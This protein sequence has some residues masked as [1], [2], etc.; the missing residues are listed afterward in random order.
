MKIKIGIFLAFIILLVLPQ[1]AYSSEGQIFKPYINYKT[2]SYPEAVAIGDV[3][4]DGK[5]DVVMTTS[6]S[7]NS[8]PVNDYKLFVFIQNSAG[9]LNPPIKYSVS[10]VPTSVDICDLN[11]DGKK[12]VV[13][14]NKGVN[15]EV[16]IQNQ[17]GGLDSGVNYSTT[18]SQS[19]KTGDFNNDGLMDV[20][21][22]GRNNFV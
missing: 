12:D 21:G 8:D 7:S 15:I 5:N 3:N 4:G 2:G 19:I 18:N 16:F 17:S 9:G 20:A 14:G 22:I 1:T 10:G 13:V 6:T 11:N